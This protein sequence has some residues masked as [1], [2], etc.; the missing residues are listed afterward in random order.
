MNGQSLTEEEYRKFE[1]LMKGQVIVRW[2]TA[3]E[4]DEAI[5]KSQN[6]K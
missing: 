4:F 1:K 2:M 5:R 3:N 6:G